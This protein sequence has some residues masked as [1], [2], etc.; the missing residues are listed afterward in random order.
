MMNQLI[1][2]LHADNLS[3]VILHE[4]RVATYEGH[5]VRTL[6]HILDNEPELLLDAKVAIAAAGHTAAQAMKEG[7]VV[8]V[9]ADYISEQAY[10]TLHAAGIKVTAVH[11]VGH[12]DFLKI[13]ERMGETLDDN[14]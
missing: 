14:R 5:G 6:Y 2:R 7:G 9:Y 4:G 12:H 3:L 8:E 10:D 13:W 11:K 1:D